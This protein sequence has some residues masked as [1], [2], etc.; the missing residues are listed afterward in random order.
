MR[1]A[2]YAMQRVKTV[3]NVDQQSVT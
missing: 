2:S 3:K 1:S